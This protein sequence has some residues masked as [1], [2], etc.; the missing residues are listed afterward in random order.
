MGLLNMPGMDTPEGQGLLSA[1][2]ALL[3]ARKMPGGG[4][5]ANALGDAGQQ[6]MGARSHAQDRMSQA[7]DQM[8]RR[9]MQDFQMQSMAAETEQR[10]AALRTKADE[11]A[12]RA[13]DDAAVR[14]QLEGGGGFD[15]RQ[16]LSSNPGA[17][18]E[19]LEQAMKFNT[20]LTPKPPQRDTVAPGSSV[21]EYGPN[22]PKPIFTAPAEPKAEALPEV[23]KLISQMERLPPGSPF[24]KVYENAIQKATT[25]Q[26]ATSV[27][28]NTEKPLLNSVAQG[29]GKQIDDSLAAARAAIPAI[30]TAH[31]LMSAVDSGK[32][33][34]GPGASFRVLGL[35]IGQMLGVGGSNGAEILQN[36]RSAIQSMAQ[37]ELDAAQQMKGQGQITESERDIIR[38]AASGRIDDLTAPEVK[39]LAQTMEKT[40]KF[41]IKSHRSNVGALQAMPGAAPLIPFYQVPDPQPYSP[42]ASGGFRVL[43]KE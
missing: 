32:L 34:S 5:F 10:Q 11:L 8:A 18:L 14:R 26:P 4:G 31:R 17:S 1:A 25:H 19:G 40:A 2:F 43:G 33:V 41:K 30:T 21:I 15:P 39:L 13:T 35:Q 29:L 27:N 38:R 12:R 24:R 3:K 7:Q 22:G 20:A 16:F 42:P 36:T 9:K 6:Y 28:V 37:A 23:A